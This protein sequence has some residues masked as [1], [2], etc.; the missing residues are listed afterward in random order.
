MPDNVSLTTAD[1][2][3]IKNVES[4]AITRLNQKNFMFDDSVDTADLFMS[5][6]SGDTKGIQIYSARQNVTMTSGHATAKFDFNNFTSVV[7]P[8][9]FVTLSGND[10]MYKYKL[11]ST[12]GVVSTSGV[13]VDIISAQGK[14]TISGSKK[15]SLV[16]NL[17]AIGYA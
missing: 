14:Y 4:T 3:N 2:N 13:T 5:L 6:I 17:L 11:V 15:V 8:L 12:T 7:S 10:S 1:I 9:V 16:V